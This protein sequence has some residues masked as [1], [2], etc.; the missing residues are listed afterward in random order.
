MKSPVD[1]LLEVAY[2]ILQDVRMAYPEYEDGS[3]RDA[4]RLTSCARTRGIGLFCLDLP[5]LDSLLT[6]G[7]RFG[8]LRLHGPLTRTWKK[9]YPVPQL[10]AGLWVRVFD[11]SLCLKH[12]FDVNAVLMLRQLCCLGKKV[13]LT[14]TP[15]RLYAAMEAF[16]DIE[17]KMV[18]PT[19]KWKA[20]NLDPDGIGTRLH[21]RD[22]L[23]TDLPLF[24]GN[25]GYESIRNVIE[26]VQQT[27]DF[28]SNAIGPFE[29]ISYSD[30]R[31][32]EGYGS[33]FKHGPGAVAERTGIVDKYHHPYWTAKLE[34]WFPFREC[35]AR[36][37]NDDHAPIN[38]EP[39]SRIIAVPKTAKGPRLIAAE[40]TSHQWCQQ[41]ILDF[42]K[43]RFRSMFGESFITL[44][45]QG[46]SRR[47]ALQASLD[48]S[49]ATIDLS[50]A[51]DRLSCWAVERALRHN[52]LLLHA[53]HSCR[54]RY[55]KDS[56][57]PSASWVG[58][59]KFA[60]QGTAVTFPVQS[61]FFLMVAIGC[62]LDEKPS[63]RAINALRDKVRVFGDDIIVPND[64][65]A[66]VTQVLHYLGLKVNEDKSFSSGP[67]RESCGMDAMGG[68]DVTPVKPTCITTDGPTSVQSLI[69]LSNNLF[70]RGFWHASKAVERIVGRK[71]L[72]N[73][74]IVGTESGL[75]GR[76]S[77]CGFSLHHLPRR[78][79]ERLHRDEVRC[80]TFDSKVT[81]KSFGGLSALAQFF[82][83]F[84]PNAL[85]WENGFAERPKH[86]KMLRWEPLYSF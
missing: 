55:A 77:F 76:T 38:H 48:E 10:Y 83:E 64:R 12:D 45:N 54:T 2:G 14:C 79:N 18:P 42:L 69:D 15:K 65:Y 25:Q 71:V 3:Q 37:F 8:R 66:V 47:M 57:L 43:R 6:E 21:L 61:L 4:A 39:A 23:D 32:S 53:L 82:A 19:L 59:K 35:G 46:H 60:S 81:R 85:N 62:C 74:P 58:L 50:S 51:S 29:P 27:A 22:G 41:L 44:G 28:L 84:N 63:W 7:I 33:G 40:P 73:L 5:H 86:R 56:I 78:Y 17:A 52:R 75:T 30:E 16:H 9:S 1:N 20:D 72:S 68:Y 70:E 13:Q 49:L 26:R 11:S 24:P 31:Y 80:L 36:S 67:F 34:E